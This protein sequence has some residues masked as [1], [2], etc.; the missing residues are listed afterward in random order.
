MAATLRNA[1]IDAKHSTFTG[2]PEQIAQAVAALVG[3][4]TRNVVLDLKFSQFNV[5]ANPADAQMV[6]QAMEARPKAKK[7]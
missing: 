2:T 5:L 4:A 1:T 7:A 6:R 3:L